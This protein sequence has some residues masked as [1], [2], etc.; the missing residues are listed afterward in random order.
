[1]R[2]GT[3]L[4]ADKTG[5]FVQ[6][7]RER[8]MKR[9]EERALLEKPARFYAGFAGVHAGVAGM[10]GCWLCMLVFRLERAFVLYFRQYQPK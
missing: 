3:S 6:R 9:G 8:G 2:H 7:E 5:S 1:M 10:L 4:H